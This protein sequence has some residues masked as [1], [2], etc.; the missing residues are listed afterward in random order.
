MDAFLGTLQDHDVSSVLSSCEPELLE[1]MRQIDIMVAHKRSEWESEMQAVEVKLHT[2]EEEL[3][4]ARDLVQSTNTEAS[5][6]RQQL[7]DTQTGRQESITK[8]EEQLQR[9]QDELSK[10]KRSYEKLQRKQLKEARE[11]A[12]SQEE[13]RTELTRLTGKIGEFRQRSVEWE[14]QRIQYQK[15]VASLE[16]QR[17][18][19][20]EQFQQ[21]HLMQRS[22]GR[23]REA[24][25]GEQASR[26]EA[27]L[28]RG[29]LERAQDALR[30]QELQLE[31]LDLLQSELGDSQRERQVSG[32]VL[33]EEKV[34]LLAT[35]D[36]QDEFV[37]SSGL[38]LQQLRGE[39]ARLNQ[40]LQAKDHVIR[41]LEDCLGDQGV[42]SGLAPLRREL[43]KALVQLHASRACEVHLKAQTARLRESLDILRGSRGDRMKDP[44][45]KQLEE[46]HS[47]SVG[48][49]KR[50]RDELQ[51]VEQTRRGE[52][53][54]MRKEVSQLTN[55]LHQRDITIATLSGSASGIERQLRAEVERAEHRATELKVTQVQLKTLKMEN[56][57]LTEMLE[58][59]DSMSS[60]KGESS[61]APPWG[62]LEQENQQLRQE[63]AEVRARLEAHTQ[64]W[65]DKL[66]QALLQSQDKLDQVR[67]AEERKA[68]D[69][70]R[71]HREEVLALEMKM[72]E[73][74][75]RY[76]EEIQS[77][78]R[79]LEAPP[80][81]PSIPR[82][83]RSSSATPRSPSSSSSS[84]S[85]CL[86]GRTSMHDR[87]L[88]LSAA[89]DGSEGHRSNSSSEDS[90]HLLGQEQFSQMALEGSS[91][92]GSVASRFL[93]EETLR[94]QEL[95]QRL[96]TH[97]ENMRE[98]T[99]KT[100]RKYLEDSVDPISQQEP[101]PRGTPQE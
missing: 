9:M 75:T 76:K 39:L 11:G 22:P 46:E 90:L 98:D 21:F 19:L 91:P 81:P 27:Q 73:E 31:R 42:A 67:S 5:I 58:R 16:T 92:P 23:S 96:D 63:L 37:R 95:L 54:G 88:L 60:K 24:E 26:A 3:K 55:E 1:L 56:Q 65:Q 49:V 12:K 66:E 84:S 101:G 32:T 68:K 51:K 30:A 25:R 18:N 93:E 86:E 62:S 10:L 17:M 47:R 33:S 50:L 52:V 15:Q 48:E 64:T 8:Y 79:R 85:C 28:L 20:A 61:L 40:A 70:Q 59:L 29:Q 4:S 7:E 34:E 35:L 44:E 94:S 99:S 80:Q 38:Q 77:L 78:R 45:Q 57:H 53:E 43:E 36:T 72:Q 89:P 71:K 87:P 2:R 100:V 83:S 82:G 97:I 14:Q 69:V 6:L 41:S 13:D 74:T